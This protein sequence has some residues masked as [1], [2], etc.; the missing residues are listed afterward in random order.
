MKR[1]I[2]GE[3]KNIEYKREIPAR[4]EKLLKDIIAFAN[5]SGGQVVIGVEYNGISVSASERKRKEL[6]L[7]GQRISYDT[8]MEIGRDFEVKSAEQLCKNMYQEAVKNC[9]TEEQRAAVKNMTIQK[10]ENIGILRREGK[11]LCPTHAYSLLTDN[12]NRNAIIQCARF[13]GEDRR[14][15]LDK[16]EMDGPIYR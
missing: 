1:R 5:T 14:I 2:R 11:E 4:H 12:P 10:L 6:E 16:R 9:K 7:E 8:M 3:N 15:F 13:K